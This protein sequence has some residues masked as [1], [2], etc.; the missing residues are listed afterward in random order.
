M[1]IIKIPLCLGWLRDS[2]AV[3]MHLILLTVSFNLLAKPRWVL[4]GEKNN[5][6]LEWD[7][8]VWTQDQ[9]LMDEIK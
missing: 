8:T 3:Y 2:L 9:L 5:L 6:A 7:N 4:R 1:S